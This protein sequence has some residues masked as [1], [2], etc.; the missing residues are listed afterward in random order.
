M[1]EQKK[2]RKREN[3][4]EALHLENIRKA[5][6]TGSGDVPVLKGVNYDIWRGEF[7]GI[8]G[9]SGSGKSTMLNILGLLDKPTG[10]LYRLDGIDVSRMSDYELT[11]VTLPSK[12]E[13]TDKTAM[14]LQQW[15]SAFDR[16]NFTDFTFTFTN[17]TTNP[18]SSVTTQKSQNAVMTS[19]DGK[20]IHVLTYLDDSVD[21]ERYYDYTLSPP[22]YY[23]K[24]ASGDWESYDYDGEDYY[25]SILSQILVFGN[26][27]DKFDYDSF[28]DA[29]V[30]ENIDITLGGEV[31]TFDKAQLKFSDGKII[32]FRL[33]MIDGNMKSLIETEIDYTKPDLTLPV[34]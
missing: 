1:P 23:T 15:E 17:S 14:S 4:K 28:A 33:S 25:E 2:E 5:Y 34:I 29:Y 8:M 22:V 10:G 27:Y 6:H 21:N 32:G 18:D 24:N 9:T 3:L 13:I 30:C 31:F 11:T 19:G 12:D 26:L 16:K 20:I 7:I